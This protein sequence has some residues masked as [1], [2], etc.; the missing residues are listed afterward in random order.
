MAQCRNVQ[1]SRVQQVPDAW[2]TGAGVSV[3]VDRRSGV[4]SEPPPPPEFNNLHNLMGC[5]G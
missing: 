5:P 4:W 2:I 1:A 3:S